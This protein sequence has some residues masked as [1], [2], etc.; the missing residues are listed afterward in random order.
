MMEFKDWLSGFIGAVIFALGLLPILNTRGIGPA[1]FALPW[2]PVQIFAYIV[3][4]AGFYLFVESFIEIT[5]SNIIGWWSFA[6]AVAVIAIGLLPLLNR[7]GIGPAWFDFPWLNETIYR[8][9]FIV[10]G[11]FL[12]IA[13]F[14]M[15]M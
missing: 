9:I 12:M 10:E 2:L 6:V 7:F 5:N 14:A 3:A 4:I 15:E 13:T 8:V 1:W 11:F